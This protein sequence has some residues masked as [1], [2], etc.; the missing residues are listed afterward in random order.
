MT[1]LITHPGAAAPVDLY[2]DTCPSAPPAQ[3]DME[4]FGILE[5]HLDAT[6]VFGVQRGREEAAS[7]VCVFSTREIHGHG[8]CEEVESVCG[9]KLSVRPGSGLSLGPR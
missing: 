8:V 9:L 4:T 3:P 7:G 2:W 5:L 6:D 1:I